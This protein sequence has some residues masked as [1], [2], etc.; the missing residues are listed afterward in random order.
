MK[1]K[2]EPMTL[3]EQ[4]TDEVRK[5]LL[6]EVL[7]E[8]KEKAA[9]LLREE[10]ARKLSEEA[11]EAQREEWRNEI[12][13]EYFNEYSKEV[14]NTILDELEPV[15]AD[16]R[17]GV[18]TELATIISDLRTRSQNVLDAEIVQLT[19]AM[20]MQIAIV[21]S[22]LRSHFAKELREIKSEQLQPLISQ[23][24]QDALRVEH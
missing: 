3:R 1:R 20:E 2:F 13:C 7:A 17:S 9:H 8:V 10:I 14:R 22:S 4:L 21:A 24:L 23:A 11:L 12:L 5:I 16:I 19:K 18:E 15:V 6:N